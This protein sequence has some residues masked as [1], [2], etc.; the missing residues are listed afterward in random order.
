MLESESF[1]RKSMSGDKSTLI[2]D[3]EKTLNKQKEN[4]LVNFIQHLFLVNCWEWTGVHIRGWRIRVRRR[5]RQWMI[6]NNIVIFII[7]KFNKGNRVESDNKFTPGPG[8]YK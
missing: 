1:F 4:D 5:R 2:V 8:E 7:M 6:I 3:L